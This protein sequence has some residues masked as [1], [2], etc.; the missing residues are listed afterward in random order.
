M[1]ESKV[2]SILFL[3]FAFLF[4]IVPTF[5]VSGWREDLSFIKN[6]ISVR[7]EFSV[8]GHQFSIPYRFFLAASVIMLYASLSHHIR[9]NR[10]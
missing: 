4:S 7:V 5:F 8:F 9:P 3:L 1:N 6:L 2:R 10:N